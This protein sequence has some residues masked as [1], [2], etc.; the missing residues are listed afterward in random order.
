MNKYQVSYLIKG[1]G[2]TNCIVFSTYDDSRARQAVRRHVGNIILDLG[3]IPHHLELFSYKDC[4]GSNWTPIS[5]SDSIGDA[6]DK[7]S[8]ETPNG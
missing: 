2:L 7:R 4:A 5:L 6:L 8:E 3:V 1:T